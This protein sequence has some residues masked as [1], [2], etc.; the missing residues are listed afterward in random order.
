[1]NANTKLWKHE[2]LTCALRH[3]A[4][5]C[6]CGYVLLVPEHPFSGVRHLPEEPIVHGGITFT[7][8]FDDLDSDGPHMWA[9]GFDMAHADDFSPTDILRCVRTDDECARET[10]W[11]AAQ[12]HALVGPNWAF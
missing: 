11:L 12:L 1:M 5:G 9:F 7:G 8:W 4:L 3:N 10:E 6:P 2:G